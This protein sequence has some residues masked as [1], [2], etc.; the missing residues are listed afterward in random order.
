MCWLAHIKSITKAVAAV[1]SFWRWVVEISLLTAGKATA[2]R[3]LTAGYLV[4]WSEKKWFLTSTNREALPVTKPEALW[5]FILGTKQPLHLK[6]TL[7]GSESVT[8]YIQSLTSETKIKYLCAKREYIPPPPSPRT[9]P[10][11]DPSLLFLSQKQ[12]ALHF[13]GWTDW[14]TKEGGQADTYNIGQTAL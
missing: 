5:H 2:F 7:S 6:T 12:F 11:L 14:F 9:I 1:Y 3:L 10:L 4:T 13:A 8:V